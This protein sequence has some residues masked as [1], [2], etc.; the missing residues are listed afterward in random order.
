MAIAEPRNG[1]HPDDLAPIVDRHRRGG[2]APEGAKLDHDAVPPE[3]RALAGP[4]AVD[5]VPDDLTVVVD[6]GRATRR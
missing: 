3:H 1:A 5:E 4:V 2:V 6:A